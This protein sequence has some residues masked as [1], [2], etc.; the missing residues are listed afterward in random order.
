MTTA[1]Y[2]SR[3]GPFVLQPEHADL[4]LKQVWPGEFELDDH[5]RFLRC[6]YLTSNGSN[7]MLEKLIE[8]YRRDDFFGDPDI[9]RKIRSAWSRLDGFTCEQAILAEFRA[10]CAPQI[11]LSLLHAIFDDPSH[12]LFDDMSADA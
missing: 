8:V 11:P 1:L 7:L 4:L 9:E 2:N 3:K 10:I 6:L 12:T 5:K